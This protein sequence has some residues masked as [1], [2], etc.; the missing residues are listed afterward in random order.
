MD[1]AN[2]QS[3]HDSLE[4]VIIKLSICGYARIPDLVL[5]GKPLFICLQPKVESTHGLKWSFEVLAKV[6]LWRR[7]LRRDVTKIWCTERL[8]VRQH[9]D[10]Y[11]EIDVCSI[12]KP[13][14]KVHQ[15]TLQL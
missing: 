11:V 13:L 3:H 9:Y 6:Y 7:G 1:F 5:Q 10:R 4:I 2:G 14:L 15:L 12:F 8:N